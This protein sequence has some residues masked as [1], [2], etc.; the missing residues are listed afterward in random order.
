MASP[1]IFDGGKT[2]KNHPC[3]ALVFALHGWITAGRHLKSVRE[4]VRAY[5]ANIVRALPKRVKTHRM[6]RCPT[7]RS[8]PFAPL[9]SCLFRREWSSERASWRVQ[10]RWLSRPHILKP[11][12]TPSSFSAIHLSPGPKPRAVAVVL[13]CKHGRIRWRHSCML[14]VTVSAR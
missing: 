10:R 13:F 9:L 3:R 6:A 12:D 11:G 5:L 8:P 7:L 14:K 4:M 2:D 1:G